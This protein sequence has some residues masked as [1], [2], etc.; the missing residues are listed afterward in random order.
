MSGRPSGYTQ[1]MEPDQDISLDA[2][3]EPA[4]DAEVERQRLH[5]TAGVQGID[6]VAAVELAER[7]SYIEPLAEAYRAVERRLAMGL[8]LREAEDV[9]LA[10]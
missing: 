2:P 9:L 6:E 3:T 8:S 1:R 5:Q 10:G 4:I 7:V